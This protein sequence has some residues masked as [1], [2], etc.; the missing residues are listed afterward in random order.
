QSFA[1]QKLCGFEFVVAFVAAAS[2]PEGVSRRV[3]L[4]LSRLGFCR[5]DRSYRAAAVR[6]R[7]A[8]PRRR[9]GFVIPSGPTS[10]S[11]PEE[12]AAGFAFVAQVFTLFVKFCGL[13]LGDLVCAV[14][15]GYCFWLADH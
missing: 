1:S 14:R 4:R 13:G 12:S 7:P 3:R 8:R 6:D 10:T 9:M 11:G 15:L 2:R 5:R